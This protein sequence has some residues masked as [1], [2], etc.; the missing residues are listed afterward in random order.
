MWAPGRASPG[1]T[2]LMKGQSQLPP[3]LLRGPFPHPVV[4]KLGQVLSCKQE[5]PRDLAT[6]HQ[7]A[8]P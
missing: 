8:G 4:R 7:P 1:G 3:G 6:W 2:E 5:G